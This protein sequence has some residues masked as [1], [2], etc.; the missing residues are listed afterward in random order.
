MPAPHYVFAFQGVPGAFSHR[1]GQLFAERLEPCRPPE[2]LP[3]DT[4]GQVFEAVS[5]R[6]ARYGVIPLENSTIGSIT[7]NFDLLWVH[8]VFIVGEVSMPIHHHLLAVEGAELVKIEAVYSHPAALEQ[9]RGFF[10]QFGHLTAVA[11]FDTSGAA[12]YVSESKDPTRAAIAGEFAASEY[13]LAVLRRN[14]EDYPH[15]RT[16]FGI[17]VASAENA[18]ASVGLP[19]PPYKVSCAVK[20]PHVPG[21]L[22]RLLTRIAGLD[23]NLTKIESRPIP[24]APWHYRFFIDMELTGR[25]QDA[26]VVRVLQDSTESYRL[27]GRYPPWK[28]SD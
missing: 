9:C 5:T 16:R 6:Q 19:E 3:C 23:I 15:N 21:S 4:F 1:A 8:P 24:E 28:Y 2:F 20:L 18:G 7:A 12:R 14:I 27:L 13:R 11:Y 22:A 25:D 10:Q 26:S 17:I